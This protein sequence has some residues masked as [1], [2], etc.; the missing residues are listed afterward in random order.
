[1]AAGAPPG[2]QAA[3]PQGEGGDMDQD[4]FET[5]VAGLLEHLMGPAKDATV[6]KLRKAKNV[7][8]EAGL[9][10]YH[11]VQM[12]ATQAEDANRELDIDILLGVAT[13]IA[14]SLMKMAQAAKVKI[15]DPEAFMA[16][17]IL[18]AVQAY[19]ASVPPG[20]EEQEAA[21][22]MLAQMQA[23][24]SVEQGAAELSRLGQK[25]GVDPFKDAQ[26]ASPPQQQ[27]SP[28]TQP[29]TAPP[30]GLMGA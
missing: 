10:V 21:K 26:Q 1:M 6:K 9:M 14:E 25:M 4:T 20:S 18:T 8:R 22:A 19:V 3:P 5:M 29:P 30:A 15:A 17:A 11:Y 27:S 7:A 23:D 12:A 28:Q 2:P 24:G 16:E 13:E